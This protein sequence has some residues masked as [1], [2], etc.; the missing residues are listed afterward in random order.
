MAGY[1]QI[2]P[3]YVLLTD[4]TTGDVRIIQLNN[5]LLNLTGA[6]GTIFACLNGSILDTLA[7][8]PTPTLKGR[9]FYAT[10]EENLYIDDGSSYHPIVKE[11]NDFVTGYLSADQTIDASVTVDII[12]FDTAIDDP[13]SLFDSVNHNITIKNSGFYFVTLTPYFSDGADTYRIIAYVYKNSN[14]IYQ[15]LIRWADSGSTA[16]HL[17]MLINLAANDV[18]D[19]RIAQSDSNTH[20]LAGG[21]NL[22]YFSVHRVKQ[23]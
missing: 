8:R 19:F 20:T 15:R 21:S 7:N 17:S 23:R 2:K 5:D 1:A 10:D 18:I 9:F 6:D 14:E 3:S 16:D 12:A 13:N 11:N 4:K 22:T